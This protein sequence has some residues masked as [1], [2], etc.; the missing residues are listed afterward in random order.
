M[1]L[2]VFFEI[3]ENIQNFE[4]T[5]TAVKNL[6]TPQKVVNENETNKQTNLPNLDE[7]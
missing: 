3:R 4:E 2:K 6:P 5:F 1:M 7:I